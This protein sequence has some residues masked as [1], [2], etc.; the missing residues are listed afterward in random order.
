MKLT[1]LSPSKKTAAQRA[2]REHY[3][4]NVD[5]GKMNVKKTH[6]MLTRVKGLIAEA[7][8][9]SSEHNVYNNPSFNKLM[10]MEQMLS[11]HYNDLRSHSTSIVVE[12]EEV[13]KSQVIL[14][15]QDLID[16]IQKMVEQVSKMNVEELPAVVTGITNEIGTTES[17]QFN[18]SAGEAL[19]TLQQSLATAKTSLDGALGAITGES[20]GEVA[21]PF[22]D[23]SEEM[24][25]DTDVE[26]DEIPDDQGIPEMPDLDDEEEETLGAAGRELR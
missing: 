5:L 19:S 4:V 17:E 20:T 24:E 15:A 1:E 14:A 25:M 3:E 16:Q 10:M 13:Q 6:E 23:G 18:S 8:V 21:E 26:T 2:L 7:R 22:D 11:T 9:K 12:N